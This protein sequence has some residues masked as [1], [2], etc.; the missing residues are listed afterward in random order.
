MRLLLAAL[1]RNWVLGTLAALGVFAFQVVVVRLFRSGIKSIGQFLPQ[2]LQDFLGIGELP[3]TQIAGFLSLAYQHPF[4]LAALLAIPIA[5]ASGALAGELER[6]SI[7]FLLARPVSPVW[8]VVSA[9]IS[10]IA[11]CTII[12]AA[13]VAGTFVGARITPVHPPPNFELLLWV[14]ANLLVLTLAI[15]AVSL[16]FSAVT[17]ERGDAIGWAITIALIMYVWNFLGQFWAALHPY[18]QYSVFYYY[19][20]QRVFLSGRPPLMELQVLGIVALV[21]LIA[22]CA[23]Y[24]WREFNV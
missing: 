18:V 4:V 16:F 11:W 5:I 15:A 13:A 23:V 10:C 19:A 24:R 17:D 6:K 14:A 20:P 3:L 21:S 22:A 7:G 12:V 9:M 8:L 2:G 1:R